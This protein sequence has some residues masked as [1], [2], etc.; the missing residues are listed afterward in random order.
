MTDPTP[1]IEA[2][3]MRRIAA[4]DQKA[5]AEFYDR[6]AALVYGM[7]VRVLENNALAEEAMQD[8]FLKVWE[9]A[10]QWNPERGKLVTWLLTLARYTAI[11]RLRKERSRATDSAA[12]LD[13]LLHLLSD[14]GA[15][16]AD[17]VTDAQQMRTLL[18]R[19]PAEQRQALE[20]AFF[21]GYTHQEIAERLGQ[22][23]GTVKSRIRQALHTL[24]GLWLQLEG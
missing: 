6:F 19:L 21:K 4:H 1:A 22:P 13:Q 14:A 23:L 11:D 9:Q 15:V 10:A 3:L 16:D 20:L 5:M 18:D 24:K 17:R 12:D 2:D 7:A 8:T